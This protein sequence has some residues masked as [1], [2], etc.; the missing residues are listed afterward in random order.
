MSVVGG[1]LLHLYCDGTSKVA[2]AGADDSCKANDGVTRFEGARAELTGET[3]AETMRK[4]RRRG[5]KFKRDGRVLCPLCA[6]R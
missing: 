3:R 2:G 6:R 4:A 5:W 1:Y